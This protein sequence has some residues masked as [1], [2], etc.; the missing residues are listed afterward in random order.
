MPDSSSARTIVVTGANSGLGFA[1]SKA[2]LERGHHVVM[3][4]R[5]ANKATDAAERL[6]RETGRVPEIRALDLG[7]LT[8]VRAFVDEWADRPIDVLLN[9]AGVMGLDKSTTA[10]GFEYQLGVNHLG[11]FALTGLLLPVLEANGGGRVVNVSS[12][13]HRPGRVDLNDPMYDRRRYSRWG[14]YFQSKLANLLFTAELDRRLR[15]ADSRVIGLCSHPGTARTEI[16]KVGDS[17]TN[18]IIRRF[19]PVIFR[20][21]DQGAESLVRACID[22]SV[23]GGEFFGPRWWAFGTPRLETP[24]RRARREDDA[25]RLWELSESLTGVCYPL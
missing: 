20:T 22:E 24:S 5:N 14:A 7:D 12:I 21:A 9:N 11:H 3:A 4:C 6:A 23:R 2:L 10:D 1:A 15:A 17:I 25:R 16:G 18:R 19:A 8:S 13:G